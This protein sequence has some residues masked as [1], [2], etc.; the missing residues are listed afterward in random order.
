MIFGR[1]IQNLYY[2]IKSSYILYSYAKVTFLKNYIPN[3]SA[4]LI[5][6]KSGPGLTLIKRIHLYL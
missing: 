4:T 5:R 2:V 1:I 3:E 6:I